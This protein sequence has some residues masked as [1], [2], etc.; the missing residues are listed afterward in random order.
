MK[1]NLL[2]AASA[3]ACLLAGCASTNT[4]VVLDSVGPGPT[5][6]ANSAAAN[7]TLLVYSAYEV[8]ANFN[9]RDDRRHQYSDYR[10]LGNDG[11]LV[12]PV[13]ND[14]GTILQRPASVDLPVGQYRV[15]AQANGYGLVT[16]PV[17]IEAGR[18]TVL[19]LE[20]G[21]KWPN[22]FGENQT[23]AVR[24]PDGEIVGWR[25]NLATK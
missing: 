11:K 9:I 5:E 21:I 16:V 22:Q 4:G 7:G 19:H 10:I 1:L 3:A 14:S 2:L 8:N 20:G 23:N 25:S 12:Q 15:V 18:T 17:T 24:L 6:S 13:V